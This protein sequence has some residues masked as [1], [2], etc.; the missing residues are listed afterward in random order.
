MRSK[1]TTQNNYEHNSRSKIKAS[2]IDN[3]NKKTTSFHFFT[4]FVACFASETKNAVKE[5]ENEKKILIGV[6]TKVNNVEMN[7]SKESSKA[8]IEMS[9]LSK[10]SIKLFERFI[11]TFS[12]L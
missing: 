5:N 11:Y 1:L 7:G 9:H 12:I 8:T 4:F 2:I 3:N 6:V 10:K